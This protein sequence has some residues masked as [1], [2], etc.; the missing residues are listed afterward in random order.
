MTRSFPMVKPDCRKRVNQAIQHIDSNLDQELSLATVSKTACYSPFHFHRVFS[1]V[2]QEPLNAYINRRRVEKAASVLMRQKQ[3]PITEIAFAYGFNSNSSFTRAFKKF[4]GLSPVHFRNA[5]SSRFSKVKKIY[6][7]NGQVSVVFEQ[8]ICSNLQLIKGVNVNANI[9]VKEM[10]TMHLACINHIGHDYID[11]AFSRLLAWAEP[12]GLLNKPDVKMLT[13]F[14]DSFKITAPDKIRISACLLVD[15][16]LATES[17]VSLITLAKSKCVV[18]YFEIPGDEFASTWSKLFV[19]LNKQGYQVAGQNC[20]QIHH[21]NYRTHP[22][23][24]FIVDLC[25]PVR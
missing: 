19:W 8:D 24:K 14:H 1:V 3:V 25:I 6:S 16:P 18:G 4:Y 21:N 20:F 5:C 15:Q 7:K 10:P 22:E 11:D 2:T 17:E 13:I 23:N 9:E 12:K